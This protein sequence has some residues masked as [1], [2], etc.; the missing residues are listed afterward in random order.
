MADP[1]AP[2]DRPAPTLAQYGI[3]SADTLH[4]ILKLSNKLMAPFS[5]NLERQYRISINEFRLLMMIGR[6]GSAAGH[7]LAA[8]TGVNIM[9]VSR[10][11]S[12]LERHGRITVTRDPAN[13]RRKTLRLTEEGERLYAIMRPQSDLVG[14]YLLSALRPDEVM[15]LDRFLDTLIDTLEATDEKGRSLFMERTRPA[16]GDRP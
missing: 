1:T 15:A 12:A 2:R 14:D 10:A 3:D 9:S 13:R 11:V 4:R 6:Y 5:A 16:E 8:M 7:E